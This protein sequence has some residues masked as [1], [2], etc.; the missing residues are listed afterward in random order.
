MTAKKQTDELM[1]LIVQFV[2]I[3]LLEALQLGEDAQQHW[4]HIGTLRMLGDY[5]LFPIAITTYLIRILRFKPTESPS[6]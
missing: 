1:W 5:I 3:T 4:H 6:K 2:I